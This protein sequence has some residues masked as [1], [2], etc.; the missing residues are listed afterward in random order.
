MNTKKRKKARCENSSHLAQ[1]YCFK[2]KKSLDLVDRESRQ[3]KLF[4]YVYKNHF[5][6]AGWFIKAY[7]CT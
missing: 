3:K 5:N 4:K 2:E 7:D 1:Q 6:D